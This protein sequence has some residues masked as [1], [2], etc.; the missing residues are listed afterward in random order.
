MPVF[1]PLISFLALQGA[2]SID[3]IKEIA[4]TADQFY[5]NRD[6]VKLLICLGSDTFWKKLTENRLEFINPDN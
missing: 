4:D 5:I 1:K 3:H 2:L 6:F